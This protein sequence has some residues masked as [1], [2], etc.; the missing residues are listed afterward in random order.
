VVLPA[1]GIP[2]RPT[3]SMLYDIFW[4]MNHVVI[5]GT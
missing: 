2:V 5:I 4:Q 3:I 1:P